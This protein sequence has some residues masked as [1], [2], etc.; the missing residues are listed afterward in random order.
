MSVLPAAR[1]RDGRGLPS[2]GGRVP[3]LR[4][5]V[6]DD[7]FLIRQA[8]EDLVRAEDGWDLVASCRDLDQLMACVEREEP[9]LVITDIKMPPTRSDEGLRAARALRR[10]HPNIG[11]V[12]LSQY[13]DLGYVAE[14]FKAGAHRRGY[15]LKQHLADRGQLGDTVRAVAAGGSHVDAEVL[16]IW[17][18]SQGERKVMPLA[19]LT[20]R[21]RQVLAAMAS[22]R[23]NAAIAGEMAITER[24]VEKHI[25]AVFAK[26]AV[27][28]D[29]QAHARVKAVLTYLHSADGAPVE[30]ADIG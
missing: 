23:N 2:I 19:T 3:D 13:A 7:E 29:P 12:V 15:L 8:L 16:R 21:E 18:G 25:N 20:P 9:D 27:S 5:V 1:G 26:L 11:V 6:A 28:S 22:G 14:L 24:A 30:H 17:A 4:I 10:S